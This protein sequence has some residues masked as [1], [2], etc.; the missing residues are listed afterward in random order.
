MGILMTGTETVSTILSAISTVGFPIVMCGALFWKMDKQ[1]KD[2][3]EEQQ[4]LTEAI[5]NNT[6]VMQQVVD[7]LN[8]L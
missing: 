6:V 1:D 2:H 8:N 7:K 5:Q 3:K 4:K